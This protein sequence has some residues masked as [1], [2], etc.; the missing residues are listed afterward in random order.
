M[1]KMKSVLSILVIFL[2]A[3][4]LIR[5]SWAST[6]AQELY[7]QARS[8]SF[9]FK[10]LEIYN[11]ALDMDKGLLDARKDRA[12][13]LY[14]QGKH[15][16]ALED[17]TV[18]LENGLDGA[19]IRAMRA[20][21]LIALKRYKEAREDLS[22]A[23]E[24]YGQSRELILDR[25]LTNVKLKNYDEAL[26][27]LKLLIKENYN[28]RISNQAYRLMGEI[29]LSQGESEVAREYFAK[30]GG[31]DGL[32]GISFP[33]GIYSAKLVSLLGMLGIMVSCAALIFKVDLPAPKHPRRRR[34]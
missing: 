31:W 32:W 21:V 1:R 25:A 23:I 28:D 10:K 14:Y 7:E 17:L 18:C 34:R 33:G 24:H 9:M 2:C 27:D 4:V 30:A 11:E 5:L 22:R 19:D 20:K 26:K 8:E 3:I 15:K 6:S 16:E 12:F 29:F 13:I